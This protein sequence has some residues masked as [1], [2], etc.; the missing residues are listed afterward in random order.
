MKKQW[1][2][3][4]LAVCLLGSCLV[5]PA[6]AVSETSAQQTVR[7]LGILVGDEKGNLD[8]D[9]N[10]TR[11]QLTKMLVAASKYKD[12]VSAD[13]AGYSLFTDVKSGH[14]A[15]EYIR[16]AVQEG[17]VVGYTDGSFRP[18]RTVTLEEACTA[19]LRVLG[20]DASTLAGSF[21]YAQLSKASALGLRD[22]ISCSKGAQMTRRDCMYLFYNMLTAQDANGQ[23]YAETLGYTVTNGEVDYTAVILDGLSGPYV[24]DGGE[25]LG[26]QPVNIYRNGQKTEQAALN[27]YD[28]YYYDRTMSSLWIYTERVAGKV[29]ELSPSSTSP[30][31]VTVAGKTYTIGSSSA[32]YDLSVLGG[33]AKGDLVTLLLGMDDQVVGVLTGSAVNT[34]YYGVVQAAEKTVDNSG[35]AV[36]ETSVTV[37]CTDGQVRT[38]A[39]ETDTKYSVGKLVSVNVT[40]DGVTIKNL[41]SKS[42]SGKVS[43]NGTKLG[44]TPFAAEAKI[45]DT[46][47]QG[48]AVEVKADRLAGCSLSKSDVRYYLLD[49]NGNI[50]HL[51]LD[52]VTGDTWTYGYL[53]D[54]DDQSTELSINVT[55][56]Y[57]VDGSETTLRTNG[58]KYSAEAGGLAI[59]YGT[60]GAVKTMRNLESVKLDALSVQYAAAGNQ[61]YALS[62]E[63]SV[64]IR[65]NGDFFATTLSSINDQDYTLTG[66]YDAFGCPAG[67]QIRVIVATAKGT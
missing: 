63:V 40:G 42:I 26:F 49:E 18:D 51:I 24:A 38:F 62:D 16:I 59:R 20:Y 12:S 17:W 55:Y 6:G 54:V 31:S 65:K 45:L 37:A 41:S 28:V 8:L 48:D 46:T 50:E 52:D 61:K 21:P 11:A 44:S 33:G 14:W 19:V 56:T 5:I 53:V 58:I 15:S 34:L 35:Q 25:D 2:A 57:L 30:T 47:S 29:S 4:F 10:V 13:G 23:V 43:S 36:V 7:A 9:Q 27:Q 1:S 66:W 3:L 60:D 32:A 39:V 22:Q 64:Y 67:K